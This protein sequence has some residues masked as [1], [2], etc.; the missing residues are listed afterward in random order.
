[1]KQLKLGLYLIT[2]DYPELGRGHLDI[3]RAALEG[4]ADAIQIREK[5]A[6]TQQLLQTA[7]E[8]RNLLDNN[9][10]ECLFI[11]NDTVDV[12]VA[13]K[14][15]GVHVGQ[16][17]LDPRE[18]RSLCGP[19]M[20]VGVSASNIRE[21]EKA[22]QEGADYIGL[23]PIFETPSKADAAP[24]IG[25]E[26]LRLIRRAVRIP[27][28]AIGGINHDN[29]E[30][31]LEAGADGVAVISAVTMAADMEESVRGLRRLVDSYGKGRKR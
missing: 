28:V 2:G 4:G 8:M 23:G 6:G 24:P 21:A 31:V 20:L 1:M 15:D 22:E 18:T 17:D 13:A 9:G 14:A 30:S 7:L 25:L 3:A 19:A 26:G 11:V 5:E 16:N 29:A 12:A 10:S 27:I